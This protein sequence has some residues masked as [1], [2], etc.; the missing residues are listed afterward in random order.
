MRA[1]LTLERKLDF[2]QSYKASIKARAFI[3]GVDSGA[4]RRTQ[5]G[6]PV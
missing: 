6:G 1:L 3:G 5:H 4:T 2:I